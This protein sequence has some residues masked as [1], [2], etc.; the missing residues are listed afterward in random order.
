VRQTIA[1]QA[2]G[3]DCQPFNVGI[4]AEEG[5]DPS[6]M[7]VAILAFESGGNVMMSVPL[8]V[9][10]A[11]NLMKAF[12][13]AEPH[14]E[15]LPDSNDWE[16][17]PAGLPEGLFWAL[18]PNVT[19]VSVTPPQATPQGG[20]PHWTLTFDDADGSQIQ[21]AVGD[22]MCVQV[23]RSLAEVANREE[24]E[25][26]EI[27]DGDE[28]DAEFEEIDDGDDELLDDVLE[29]EED[30]DDEDEDEAER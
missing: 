29:D 3:F 30:Y 4:E 6:T 14:R 25:G 20:V 18:T 16:P 7:P 24:E 12:T 8:G 22:A 13:D 19:G 26:G 11:G 21:I 17:L 27:A 28:A 10:D 5:Q 23:I 15:S 1:F 2:T 9:G